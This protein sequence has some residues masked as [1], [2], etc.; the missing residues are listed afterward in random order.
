VCGEEDFN[1]I[2]TEHHHDSKESI[3]YKQRRRFTQETC[4]TTWLTTAAL[5][6]VTLLIAAGSPMK[7]TAQDN[8]NAT[9]T[10]PMA[11]VVQ[12]ES[13]RLNIVN[14]TGSPGNLP[15]DV[16]DVT[17][18]FVDR[19][20]AVRAQFSISGLAS[21][22]AGYLDISASKLGGGAGVRHELRAF[23][24]VTTRQGSKLPSDVCKPSVE[25]YDEASGE[26]K[27]LTSPPEPDLPA[28]Q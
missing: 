18:Q 5:A 9:F 21:G 22:H 12:G 17:L 24:K 8:P 14:R 15:P 28:P 26:T 4:H 19:L 6:I 27:Y 2:Q 3:M 1:P 23:V 10:F 25:I 13:A 20:G 11:A 16:C 7:A